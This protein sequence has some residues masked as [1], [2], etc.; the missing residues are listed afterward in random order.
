MAALTKLRSKLALCPTRIAR[1][2]S[3]CFT[4]RR[5]PDLLAVQVWADTWD[6]AHIPRTD[7]PVRF[8]PGTD[9]TVYRTVVKSLTYRRPE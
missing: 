1:V 4:T 3:V 6:D 5:D 2:Q 8:V 9:P 7:R